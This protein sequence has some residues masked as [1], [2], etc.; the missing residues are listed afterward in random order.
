MI[1]NSLIYL[2]ALA[3]DHYVEYTCAL[4]FATAWN[5]ASYILF[6]FSGFELESLYDESDTERDHEQ[7]LAHRSGTVINGERERDWN[8]IRSVMQSEYFHTDNFTRNRK[9]HK[10]S[11]QEKNFKECEPSENK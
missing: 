6:Y 2:T 7:E 9:M 8:I 5:N 1:R 4:P 10:K 11:S 3:H